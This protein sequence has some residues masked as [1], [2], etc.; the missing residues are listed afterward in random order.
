MKPVVRWLGLG[1]LALV[2][3]TIVQSVRHPARLWS[4]GVMG[5]VLASGT[6]PS[7]APGETST[8]S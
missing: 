4:S 1:A 3:A 7:S 5:R 6:E 8:A 2:V